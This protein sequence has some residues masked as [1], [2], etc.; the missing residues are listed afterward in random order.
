MDLL[1]PFPV[2]VTVDYSTRCNLR[3]TYCKTGGPAH[4]DIDM[5]EDE[6]VE[7]DEFCRAYGVRNIWLSCSGETTM[8]PGWDDKLH[9]FLNERPEY[10]LHL[11]SNFARPFT[12]KDIA[13][14]L[15]FQH[16][17]ISID[18]S[19][20]ETLKKQRTADLRNIIFNLARLRQ[21]AYLSDRKKQA[22]AFN[23]VVT[24]DNIRDIE[25]L[26]VLALQFEVPE[27]TLTEAGPSDNPKMPD[28][29]DKMT[30]EEAQ[31]FA[32]SVFKAAR[33]LV[34]HGCFFNLRGSLHGK[35]LPAI[36]AIGNGQPLVNLA[37]NFRRQE[38]NTATIGRCE[39]PWNSVAV[40]ANGDIKACCGSEETFG[41]VKEETITAIFNGSKA[42]A[43]R[44]RVLAG[45]SDSPCIGC[46]FASND[47]L[48]TFAQKLAK[49]FAENTK[50]VE[51]V[52]A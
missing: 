21:A 30:E 38:T 4:V 26:A 45:G 33:W 13:A 12:D 19:S 7:I 14:L 10:I 22:L 34:S 25:G 36:Q 49:G 48:K 44:E 47:D 50:Q 8:Y 37:A 39:L 17:Q 16:I 41:N 1:Q 23:C 46:P 5:S 42:R 32:H 11:N 3:C 6:L 40:L 51:Y 28:T 9:M 27:V 24:R 20:P 52:P 18:S 35:L 31:A 43:F 15:K 2:G 29:L